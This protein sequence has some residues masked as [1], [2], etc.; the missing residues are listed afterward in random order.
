MAHFRW[1]L[2]AVDP[3]IMEDPVSAR[4][5]RHEVADVFM[6]LAEFANV[7]KIDLA[8]AVEEKM[9]INRS[10]YP[11]EKARGIAVKYDRL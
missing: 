7:A 10:R 4:E 2:P 6:L 8:A 1:T 11:V 3:P 9:A 5:I